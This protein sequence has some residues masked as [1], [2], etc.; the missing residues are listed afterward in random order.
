MNKKNNVNNADGGNETDDESDE[1]TEDGN[2]I[3]YAFYDKG[4]EIIVKVSEGRADESEIDEY[5]NI[6][7]SEVR[8]KNGWLNSNKHDNKEM[9]KELSTYYNEE[10]CNELYDRLIKDI[11]RTNDFYKIDEAIK[12]VR[13][14]T[15]T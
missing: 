15:Y 11:L 10:T 12:I 5:K 4:Q 14:S 2:Y 3:E 6:F 13:K 8:I 9:T 7:R 1:D